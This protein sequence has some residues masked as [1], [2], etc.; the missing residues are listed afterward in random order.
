MAG[1]SNEWKEKGIPIYRRTSGYVENLFTNKLPPWSAESHL[2]WL[3]WA[4]S[5]CKTTCV[6]QGLNVF[7]ANKY[8]SEDMQQ[9]IRVTPDPRDGSAKLA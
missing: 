8:E 1:E 2:H 7:L 6:W 3:S 4:E 9:A 5:P